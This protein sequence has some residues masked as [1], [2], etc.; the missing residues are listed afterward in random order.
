MVTCTPPPGPA[1]CTRVK[2]AVVCTRTVV[3][4]PKEGRL[5]LRAKPG[6]PPTAA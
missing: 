2:G 4:L 5:L 3:T 6:A 1:T